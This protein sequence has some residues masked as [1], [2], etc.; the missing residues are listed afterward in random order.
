MKPYM[1]PELLAKVRV[2][3][4]GI[5]RNLGQLA[6]YLIPIGVLA[7]S[8]A[9]PA[10]AALNTTTT[11][12][13]NTIST[14]AL[15]EPPEPE[16]GGEGQ[17]LFR[18][19]RFR[20]MVDN[21]NTESLRPEIRLYNPGDDD[22][23]VSNWRVDDATSTVANIPVGTTLKSIHKLKL[24]PLLTA[25]NGL[26]YAGDNLR[27]F[28]AQNELVDSLSWGSDTS[29]FN[30][31]IPAPAEGYRFRR[32]PP[33]QDNNTAAEWITHT[34][35]CTNSQNDLETD[36]QNVQTGQ[37]VISIEIEITNE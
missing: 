36:D 21:Q 19:V 24:K 37:T 4:P 23:D 33:K 18:E 31:S 17:I 2:H 5:L 3:S 35:R 10:Y 14:A 7:L 30:P 13:G 29:Q 34:S 25:G 9:A 26:L 27:L 16:P 28:N 22:V 20:C 11:L 6:I 12:S 8:V 32:Q 15:P 1:A